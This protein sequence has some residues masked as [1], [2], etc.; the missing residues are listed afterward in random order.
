M[1]AHV[2]ARTGQD[3][4][5]ICNTTALILIP[6][7]THKFQI[8]SMP[9]TFSIIIPRVVVSAQLS[10]PPSEDPRTSSPRL[11]LPRT[12]TGQSASGCSNR[13]SI[14]PLHSLFPG[15]NF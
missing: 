12:P 6:Q 1:K 2:A 3:S 13:V 5:Q 15:P 7:S 14:P 8:Q 11:R 10:P 4:T 9:K